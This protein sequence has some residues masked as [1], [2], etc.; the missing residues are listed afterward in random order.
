[1]R[2]VFH[3][4]SDHNIP[5]VL[6]AALM[7]VVGAAVTISLF[8]R[9]LQ[10]E[11]LRRQG[12]N[13]L[14]AVSA[15][16]AIWATHFIAM[17]GYRPSAPVSFDPVLTLVSI[18]IA[19][20][21]SGI[22]FAICAKWKNRSGTI[23]GGGVIGLAIAAMHYV[24]ML[25]YRVEG[26]VS[27]NQAYVAG[28]IALAV[29]LSIASVA[30]SHRWACGVKRHITT[31]LL[32]AAI[33]LLHFT[34]M[35]AFQVSPI[36]GAG[37]GVDSGV[38]AAM[39]LSILI[40]AMIILGTGISSYL[41][42][43]RTRAVSNEQLQRMASHDPLTGLANRRA[44]RERIDAGFLSGEHF[45]YLLVD[46]AQFKAVND[47]Y[48]HAIGDILLVEVA[49][50]LKQIV[51]ADGFVARIGADE[52]A[53]ILSGTDEDAV[54]IA[55]EI[56]LAISDPFEILGHVII[57]G[58]NIGICRAELAVTA[59]G[60]MQQADIALNEAKRTGRD[61]V[62]FYE[63]G[64][65][66]KV[67]ARHQLETDL[68]S[69]LENQEF[70]L[71]YQPIRA[72]ASGQ[73]IGYEAL[74]RWHHPTRGL[75]PPADFIPLAEEIGC[76]V[77]IG[78]WV[79]AEA[80]REAAKWDNDKY[81]AINVS[82]VQFRS[83]LLF[84]HVTQALAT[85]GVPAHRLEIELTETAIVAQGARVAQTL[86][87]FRALGI[88]VAMDDFGTGF[89]SLAHLRDLPL[90]RIKIDRSFVATAATDKNSMAVLR[91]VTQL[92][93][94]IGI[95][96]LGEGVETVEQLRLLESLGCDAAQGYLIGKPGAVEA[97]SF[98]T[99]ADPK[100]AAAVART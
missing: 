98:K 58:C 72:L 42:D 21:G 29:G 56:L 73:T 43:D 99:S 13:F 6:L 95:A 10:N 57:T 51:G 33:V 70:R 74:I 53:I 80:C 18:L 100:F 5:F 55:H 36:A 79:L 93:R 44:L 17:L 9:T 85:S 39:A 15:G 66:E 71:V 84:S 45:G 52:L 50:R 78:G 26:L 83:P 2:I 49:A 69:A 4:I 60:L 16:S 19:V 14:T 54:S 37:A 41:I 91:A 38:F 63:E 65:L 61:R 30:A 68:K 94:D 48:G 75:V 88:T 77:A 24:G 34:G 87:A 23:I 86:E 12:W 64:M 8:R 92:G 81:V 3:L 35:A 11:G 22:G 62:F 31:A 27:W 25:A 97:A 76:I 89:S 59:E 47:T 90:D 32:G 82:P 46:L 1:M 20:V 96:T 7:C 40:G 28:S 67:A